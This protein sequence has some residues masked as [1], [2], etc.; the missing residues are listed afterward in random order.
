VELDQGCEFG[1]GQCASGCHSSATPSNAA[2]VLL[3]YDI[4][5]FIGH[6]EYDD[7]TGL[8]CL[9]FE[10]ENEG[11]FSCKVASPFTSAPFSSA[12]ALRGVSCATTDTSSCGT[13][14]NSGGNSPRDGRFRHSTKTSRDL[15]STEGVK[16]VWECRRVK[17]KGD[18]NWL[19]LKE[20]CPFTTKLHI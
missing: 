13:P 19:A 3:P 10:N 16:C 15:T 7:K 5:H 1:R 4:I 2:S 20:Q 9:V 14:F 18:A 17:K 8:G 12:A 6:G 11:V